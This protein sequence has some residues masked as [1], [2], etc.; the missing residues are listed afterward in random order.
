M[1]LRREQLG[2]IRDAEHIVLHASF[3]SPLWTPVHTASPKALIF[4]PPPYHLY[5]TGRSGYTAMQSFRLERA[6]TVLDEDMLNDSNPSFIFLLRR[7][8]VAHR[9]CYKPL[10]LSVTFAS[11]IYKQGNRVSVVYGTPTPSAS[12]KEEDRGGV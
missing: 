9:P 12:P 1:L 4:T 7:R 10:L 5:C 8:I 2:H 6:V 11:P 3:G